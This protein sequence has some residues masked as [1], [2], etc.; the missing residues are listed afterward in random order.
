MK[1]TKFFSDSPLWHEKVGGIHAL[2][3]R[4]KMS[5]EQSG[6]V[7]RLRK[8]NRI[9]SIHA[10]TAIEGNRLTL[11]QVTDVING[12]PAASG[13][14]SFSQNGT[15]FSHGCPLK[16]LFITIRHSTTKHFR[17][18]T[19]TVWTAARSSTLCWASSRTRFTSTLTSPLRR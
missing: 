5:E 10:S 1:A 4:V 16:P 8:L 11:E 2:L 6:D 14:R 19:T 3:E 13:K 12:K 9:L 17:S 18:L 7:L 15:L